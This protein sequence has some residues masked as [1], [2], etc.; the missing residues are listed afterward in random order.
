MQISLPRDRRSHQRQ[1]PH[2]CAVRPAHAAALPGA[3]DA[4]ARKR[5]S[6]RCGWVIREHALTLPALVC[7]DRIVRGV[8]IEDQA[9]RRAFVG[10]NEQANEEVVHSALIHADLAIAV[11]VRP[12]RMLQPVERRWPPLGLPLAPPFRGISS[13]PFAHARH[14]TNHTGKKRGEP[15]SVRGP[16]PGGRALREEK[17][18]GAAYFPSQKPFADNDLVCLICSMRR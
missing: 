2:P 4:A 18:R 7:L 11:F 17:C 6:Q 1:K 10:L 15:A 3:G 14:V 5:R 9:A 13:S 8:E 16:E 12:R